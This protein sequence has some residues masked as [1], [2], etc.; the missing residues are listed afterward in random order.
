M[1]FQRRKQI[2]FQKLEETGEVEIKQLA[3]E[4]DTSEITIRR[5]LKQFSDDGLL[6]R[7]H[8]GAMKV[9][10][11]ELPHQFANK[12]AVNAKA[13]DNICRRAANEI[14]DGDIIFMDC[15]ST[16]F[17][18]C[19][20]IKNKKI[21]VIT[22][23]IPVIFELQN[24]LVSLNIIGGEFDVERQAV[25]GNI[26]SEHISKYRAAKAF[27]GVDGISE[28][29]LF[30]H[31][32][33]EASITMAMAEASSYTYLLFDK[34]KFGKESYLQFAGLELTDAIITDCELIK[35]KTIKKKGIKIIHV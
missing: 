19:Q 8:G 12:T 28:N 33:K 17:R 22:N 3:V 16:V 7:T 35:M 32:E 15:G 13:K 27:L 14:A 34:T 1:N 21:K 6:Y 18:L 5:D 26:A 10:P 4:L 31:G 11:V 24:S 9:N 25:H 29:G 2:I 20:F 30:S 23:S